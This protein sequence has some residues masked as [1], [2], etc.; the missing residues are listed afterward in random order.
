MG[1]KFKGNV[2]VV[3]PTLTSTAS[4]PGLPEEGTV[5]Y[6]NGNITW[7]DGSTWVTITTSDSVI[8]ITSSTGTLDVFR[9]SPAPTGGPSFYL[10]GSGT[11]QQ[12]P[13]SAP[14]NHTHPEYAAS[15][16]THTEYAPINSPN[17]TG[18]PLISG[19]SI[20]TTAYVQT[21][22]RNSQ[23][24]KTLSTSGP[25]GTGAAGDIWYQY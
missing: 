11:W 1:L 9:L 3:F 25:S 6:V 14:S 17:F 16:H 18:T 2:G 4:I 12:L 10:S 5:A 23:G 13:S 15:S 7:Y 20:A 24:G 22:G 21:A 8:D 19:V